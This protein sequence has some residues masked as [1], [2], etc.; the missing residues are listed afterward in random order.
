MKSSIFKS[1]LTHKI[2]GIVVASIPVT[3]Y[4]TTNTDDTISAINATMMVMSEIDTYAAAEIPQLQ[5]AANKGDVDAQSQLGRY[6]YSGTGIQQD[7]KQAF[8]W[9]Y[10]AA[11][12]GNAEALFYVGRMLD[13]GLGV[14]KSPDYAAAAYTAAADKGYTRAEEAIIDSDLEFEAGKAYYFRADSSLDYKK[15]FSWMQKAADKGN[16]WAYEYLGT[17]YQ[18]GKGV[19]KSDAKAF[20]A[21]LK[22]ATNKEYDS[23]GKLRVGEMYYLGQ[24]VAQDYTKAFEW[25][26]KSAANQN[27]IAQARVGEMY[28]QGRGATKDYARAF[29][30]YHKATHTLL[31][32]ARNSAV[33]G[34]EEDKKA[35]EKQSAIAHINYE[36]SYAK[37]SKVG[38]ADYQKDSHLEIRA[39]VIEWFKKVCSA[40][41]KDSCEISK[42]LTN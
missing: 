24:G 33:Y 7:Y 6:Y 8:K 16:D 13:K 17:M 27:A 28:Y 22:V 30:A 14:S 15:A 36:D 5:I 26:V 9:L 10:K 11:E 12:A 29:E 19:T 35:Y 37:L 25:F 40:G 23:V 2:M 21:Y 41:N 32:Y 20:A 4:A 3:S 42:F 31:G 38:S 39:Q 34:D 18:E 1:M